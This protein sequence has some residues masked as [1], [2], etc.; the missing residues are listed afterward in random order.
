MKFLT[1]Q[2][3]PVDKV[4]QITEAGNKLWSNPPKGIKL[5]A[6][7][8]ILSQQPFPNTPPNTIVGIAISECEKEEAML[9]ASIPQIVAGATLQRFPI[10]E[11]TPGKGA[12]LGKKLGG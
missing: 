2:T 11:M 5:I 7:Y 12:E 1:I 6:S 9:E 8:G 4:T 3:M 10:V